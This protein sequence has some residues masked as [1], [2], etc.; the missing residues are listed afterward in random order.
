MKN[1]KKMHYLLLADILGSTVLGV[2]VALVAL[3]VP[4]VSVPL[5]MW[6][7]VFLLLLTCGFF[8]W[9]HAHAPKSVKGWL[10]YTIASIG[11]SILLFT[12]A[13]GVAAGNETA[14]FHAQLNIY[15]GLALCGAVV[16]LSGLARF[17]F[18]Q[19]YG[20]LQLSE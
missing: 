12:L 20:R 4:V 5:A 10:A 19:R 1:P 11:V 6:L 8:S 3:F 2:V 15:A 17:I 16:A 13:S 9:K 7:F 18:L 14:R